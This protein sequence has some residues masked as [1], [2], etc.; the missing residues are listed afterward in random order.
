[1]NTARIADQIAQVDRDLAEVDEQVE[2]GELDESTA[3]HLRAAY[4]KERAALEERL[5]AIDP[6]SDETDTDAVPVTRSTGRALI[7]TAVV[8]VAV[9]AVA[10]IAVFS[11]QDRSPAADVTDGV[12]TAVAEGQGVQGGQ[13]GQDLS[14]VTVEEMETIVAQHPDIAGMRMALAE[15]YVED[16]NFPKALEHYMIVLDEEPDNDTALFRVGWLTYVTGDVDLAEPFLVKALEI[17]PDFPQ[18]AWLLANVRMETGDKA[19]AVEPI[20]QVLAYTDLPA[21][22]RTEAEAL[23]KQA[24][25]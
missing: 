14:S 6:A 1:M 17:Q 10:V 22:V 12:A 3:D 23:L 21:D 9:I 15:R 20:Q 2:L 16:G 5:A 4:R 11:L 7:G 8:G 18:A 24:Q 13:S 25:S 19:G